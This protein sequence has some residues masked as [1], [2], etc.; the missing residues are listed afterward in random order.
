MEHALST[1]ANPKW[2]THV[3]LVTEIRK[4]HKQTHVIIYVHRFTMPA[5][6]LL[7][8]QTV[9]IIILTASRNTFAQLTAH[10]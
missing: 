5:Q 10:S 4:T 2:C 7:S 3:G 8:M 9:M 1:H 6:K